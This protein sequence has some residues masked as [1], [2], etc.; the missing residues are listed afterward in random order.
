MASL[1]NS[2]LNPEGFAWTCGGGWVSQTCR[3]SILQTCAKGCCASAG[4]EPFFATWWSILGVRKEER[5]DQKC[6]S[7]LDPEPQ[8]R[9]IAHT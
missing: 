9:A 1:I 3:K 8:W 4:E 6:F 2:E 5:Q 7:T